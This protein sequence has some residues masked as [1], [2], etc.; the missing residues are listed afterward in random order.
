MSASAG[1]FVAEE[2]IRGAVHQLYN[3]ERAARIQ[4]LAM[5]TGRATRSIRPGVP[6]YDEGRSDR[7]RFQAEQHFAA[8]MRVLDREDA[9]YR[10]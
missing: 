10:D 2:T 3:L 9:S 6:G 5:S 1:L 8:L 7:R 4:V